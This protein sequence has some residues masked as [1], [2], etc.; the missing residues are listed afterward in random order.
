MTLNNKLIIQ[1]CFLISRKTDIFLLIRIYEGD[2][3][4]YISTCIN[5]KWLLQF[6][7]KNFSEQSF[8]RRLGLSRHIHLHDSKTVKKN[9][10]KI[11]CFCEKS[12]VPEESFGRFIVER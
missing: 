6:R 4:E 10:G 3:V 8:L 1:Y 5:R 2:M 7:I 9:F 11:K 12:T